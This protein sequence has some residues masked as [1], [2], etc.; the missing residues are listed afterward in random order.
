MVAIEWILLQANA[1]KRLNICNGSIVHPQ[2][3]GSVEF[4]GRIDHGFLNLIYNLDEINTMSWIW[5][6]KKVNYSSKLYIFVYDITHHIRFS[7]SRGL[8]YEKWLFGL[9]ECNDGVYRLAPL[10]RTSDC[11]FDVLGHLKEHA[12]TNV[13]R[14]W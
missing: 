6:L 10:K 4:L 3:L 1:I 11:G 9:F 2:F 12:I 14:I 7:N 13:E 5:K 8:H